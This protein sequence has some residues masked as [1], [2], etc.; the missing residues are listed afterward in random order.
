MEPR[1][2][3]RLDLGNEELHL[4]RVTREPRMGNEGYVPKGFAARDDCRDDNRPE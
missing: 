1:L 2:V 4:S 3:G